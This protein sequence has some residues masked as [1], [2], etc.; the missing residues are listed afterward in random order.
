[1][2][3]EQN[4][5]PAKDVMDPYAFNTQAYPKS[6]CGE[7]DVRLDRAFPLVGT[8]CTILDLGC[9][10]GTVGELLLRRG[11]V[12]HGIDAAAPAVATAVQ[13]G[14][15]ARVG[16]LEERLDFPDAMFDVVFAGEVLEHIFDVDIVLSEAHRVLKPGGHL[17]ATTPNLAAFGRRI[18]LLLNRNPH[19]EISFTGEA[20]GHIR[21]FI[22]STLF[23]LL[24]KHGFRVTDYTSDVVNFDRQGRMRSLWLARL[25]PTL[26]KSLIVRA[27]RI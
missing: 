20:A 27:E 19:I 6:R 22:R 8:G 1:M 26:G 24:C 4:A 3:P 11:N 23:E 21:Y 25:F 17:V 2:S 14:I 7:D 10:D 12:V 15:L 16:N 13:R 9:L 18:L 5:N